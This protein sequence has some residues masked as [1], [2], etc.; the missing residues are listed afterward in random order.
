MNAASPLCVAHYRKSYF[1]EGVGCSSYPRQHIGLLLDAMLLLQS[2]Q[3]NPGLRE[4]KHL[5]WP[6]IH[7]Q[8]SQVHAAMLCAYWK[9]CTLCTRS[10]ALLQLRTILDVKPRFLPPS[11]PKKDLLTLHNKES[12]MPLVFGN[13]SQNSLCICFS[14]IHHI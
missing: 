6:Q 11:P 4:E 13:C 10:E 3:L 8:W 5:S 1:S 2:V 7:A 12:Q 9:W 14:K